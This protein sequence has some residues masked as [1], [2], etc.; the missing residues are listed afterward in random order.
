MITPPANCQSGSYEI[1]SVLFMDIVGHSLRTIE[2]QAERLS[3][4]QSCVLASAE[5]RLASAKDEL[6][7]LPTGDGM[8]LVFLRD[9]VAPVKCALEIAAS[10]RS[11]QEVRLRMGVHQGPVR[12]HADI[13]NEVNVV[14]GGINIAQ[15]VMDCG[16]AGHILVSRNV[17]EVL[18]QFRGWSDC[19][20]DL[21][22]HE[23][24][25]GVKIQL[26]SLRKD[27]L[28][29]PEIPKKIVSG[30][31]SG[32]AG[33]Q[34]PSGPSIAV[35]PFANLS[36]DKE[37]EYFSDGLAE[38]ILNLLARIPGL[39]VIARTSAFTF[40]GKEIDL[41][42]IAERLNVATVLEGSVQR[43]GNRVRINVQLI[44]GADE[45]QLW[46]QRYDR[47][48]TDIFV[49]QDEIGRAISEALKVRLAPRVQT[50]NIEAYQHYLKGQYQ[51]A[52]VTPK[53]LE[54][55]KACFESALA[56]DPHYA[57]AHSGLAQYY[58][59]LAALSIRAATE[60]APSAISAAQIA[61]AIDTENSEARS[62]LAAMTAICDYDWPAAEKHY[63]RALEREPVP[64]L[65]RF[66]YV[67]LYLFPLKRF[68][69]AIEQS[70]LALETD[71]LSMILHYGMCWSM[72][73]EKQPQAVIE[74]AH[75]A[76]EIDASYYLIWF[77]LGFAQ[78]RA[79]LTAEA[80]TSFERVV[81]LAPWFNMAVGSLA[82]VCFQVGD[83]ERG[84]YW[85]R[86]LKD[87]E[88]Y[89][90][91]AAF[92]YAA[93]AQADA[94]FE[95]LEAAYRQRDA[96]IFFIQNLPFFDAYRTGERFR[97]LLERMNL[98]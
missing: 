2:E 18:A 25:H 39:K 22:V 68:A 9:P 44:N 90:L 42:T 67:M 3:T 34:Q 8:A 23:V 95:A 72:Y 78:L 31:I 64:A 75:G 48:L 60:V 40:R 66:R 51:R 69:E 74:Y 16:D 53:S 98:E 28:G 97:A 80:I 4:L 83:N 85:F 55:A 77:V 82:A 47:E 76:L 79:G 15:R 7:S 37:N 58:Y 36:I 49:I 29:N 20:Q 13:N 5:Y 59:T 30:R 73:G 87:S 17:A 92:Y 21:G 94:M 54:Q 14:G 26:Y 71:P 56:I 57:P 91:G 27:D 35:L 43:I 12:R 52:R 63:L 93:V 6:I 33:A 24:K 62:V 81:E 89:T 88:G 10:L 11:H 70:R 86:R 50:A 96:L 65:V 61:L 32:R 41:R 38:E 19:L 45:S 84:Q 1:A 46:S